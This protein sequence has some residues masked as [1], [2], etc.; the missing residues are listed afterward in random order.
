MLLLRN[1]MQDLFRWNLLAPTKSQAKQLSPP[2]HNGEEEAP[3]MVKAMEMVQKCGDKTKRHT[4]WK[5]LKKKKEEA[6]LVQHYLEKDNEDS[7]CLVEDSFE[8]ERASA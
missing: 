5:M 3:T 4:K 7:Q 1:P 8:Y 2:F 6:R